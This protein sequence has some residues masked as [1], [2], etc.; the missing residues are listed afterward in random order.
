MNS[1]ITV[2][3]PI[4]RYEELV[5]KEIQL[6]KAIDSALPNMYQTM[7]DRYNK[8]ALILFYKKLKPFNSLF[9]DFKTKS[10]EN[11]RTMII[12]TVQ[13]KKL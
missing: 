4:S 7:V 13:S 3:L 10:E 1:E 2:N 12:E 6:Q 5:D 11:L 8:Q 9:I